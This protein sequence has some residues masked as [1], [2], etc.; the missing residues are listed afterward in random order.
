MFALGLFYVFHLSTYLFGHLACIIVS[1]L[2]SVCASFN[3]SSVLC[4]SCSGFVLIIGP[5]FLLLVRLVI[6]HFFLDIVNFTLLLLFILYVSKYSWALFWDVVNSFGKSLIF[7][8][9]LL[10][11]IG[12]VLSLW[13]I[14]L[15]CRGRPFCLPRAR[16]IGFSRLAL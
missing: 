2:I 4:F 3:I 11:R 14:T 12:T 7:Y 6:F 15:S 5:I 8:A 9:S 13:L 10:R 1:I 16:V